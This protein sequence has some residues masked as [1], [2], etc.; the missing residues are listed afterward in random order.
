[1]GPMRALLAALG[2]A[3]VMAAHS[4]AQTPQPFPRPGDT[5]APRKPPPP[6]PAPAPQTPP[7]TTQTPPPAASRPSTPP[8]QEPAAPSESEVGFPIYPAAQ[9]L[10]SYDAG[11]GQRYYIYG[12]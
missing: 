8:P 4:A 2:V 7:P 1:M 9:F 3:I 12:T 5:H 10:A 6:Q 11:R